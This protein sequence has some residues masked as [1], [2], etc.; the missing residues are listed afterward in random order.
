MRES[1]RAKYTC[2]HV[3]KLQKD[4]QNARWANILAQR[5]VQSCFKSDTFFCFTFSSVMFCGSSGEHVP[6]Q[7]LHNE[8][9]RV[10]VVVLGIKSM[11]A[12]R[13]QTQSIEQIFIGGFLFVYTTLIV[14]GR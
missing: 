2:R 14:I 9:S 12:K 10:R 3:C 7:R 8:A 1:L 4:G 5:N 11:R 13:V 6:S